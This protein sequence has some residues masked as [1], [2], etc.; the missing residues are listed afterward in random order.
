MLASILNDF[1]T[2][3]V[4]IDPIGSIPLFLVLTQRLSPAVRA[5]VAARGVFIAGGVLVSFAIFGQ[6][7]LNA[8]GISLSAFRIAGG[9]ILFTVGF[10]MIFDIEATT[11]KDDGATVE[12]HDIAVFPLALPYI[13]GPGAMLAVVVLTK[14]PT[15]APSEVVIKIMTLLAVLFASFLLLRFADRVQGVIGKTGGSV[16]QRVMGLL[17]AAAAAES[18]VRGIKEVMK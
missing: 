15:L 8:M 11:L 4:V 5:S 6:L 10:K 7:L 17:L 2:L 16:I 3:F 18:V 12:G 13:A 1:V 9:L 14:Q